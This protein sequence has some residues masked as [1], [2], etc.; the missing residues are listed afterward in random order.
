[1]ALED[2]IM[3]SEKEE[4]VSLNGLKD[5]VKN[6]RER[7]FLGIQT[8]KGILDMIPYIPINMF[9]KEVVFV[10]IVNTSR[11]MV[12]EQANVMSLTQKLITMIIVQEGWIKNDI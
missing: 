1:M 10:G 9:V 8:A 7:G 3:Y 5:F 12:H 2:K 4:Y 6:G 11:I